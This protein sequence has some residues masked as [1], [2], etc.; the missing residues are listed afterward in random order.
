MK[1][2]FT[3]CNTEFTFDLVDTSKAFRMN[4]NNL[5]RLV[6][7]T[8]MKVIKLAKSKGHLRLCNRSNKLT[9]VDIIPYLKSNYEF[10]SQIMKCIDVIK[11]NYRPKSLNYINITGSESDYIINDEPRCNKD[12]IL[13]WTWA[14][15][16]NKDSILITIF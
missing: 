5:N 15:P 7:L 1:S 3:I 12:V 14:T 10:M 16:W 13:K 11:V 8:S 2:S 9:G 4:T 6:D